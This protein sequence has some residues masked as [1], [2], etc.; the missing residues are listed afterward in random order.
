MCDHSFVRTTHTTHNDMSDSGQ[1]EQAGRQA[2]GPNP[3]R[4]ARMIQSSSFVDQFIIRSFDNVIG[5]I[6]TGLI[7]FVL[8]RFIIRRTF[9]IMEDFS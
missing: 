1:P 3:Q 2:T 6:A 5:N 4:V 9:F 7:T 8:V